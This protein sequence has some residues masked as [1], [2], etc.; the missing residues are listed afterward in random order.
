MQITPVV[1]AI[2]LCLLGVGSA[3]AQTQTAVPRG[4]VAFKGGLNIERAEDDVHGT[5]AGG[6]AVAGFTFAEPWAIEAE[7]WLPGAIRTNPEGGRHRD[8]LFSVGFRRSIGS[9]RIRPHFLVGA[10]VARTEDAFTTC[11]ANRITTLSPT[12][13][14]MLV[15]CDEP[16]VVERREERFDGTSLVPMVGAGVEIALTERV[17]LVPDVRVQVGITSVIVRPAIAVAFV[18]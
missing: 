13:Q 10:S 14:Q 2:I 12:P 17:R 15:S 7:F 5:T 11:I 1:A 18:F 9:G 4:Y 8:A 16:D 3:H 6:G